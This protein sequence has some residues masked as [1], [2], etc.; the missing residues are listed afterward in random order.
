[1]GSIMDFLRRLF[2]KKKEPL[3][4]E[5][6]EGIDPARHMS[7]ESMSGML[8]PGYVLQDRYRILGILGIGDLAAV[9]QA[10]DL[11]F[12]DV[13]KLVAVKE[14]INMATDQALREQIARNCKREG[15]ILATL[16]HPAV[17]RIY[18]YFSLG[19]RAYLIMEYIQGKD[20]ES[21][22]NS[23]DEF[24][25]VE[26]VRE[27][28]IELCDV[29]HYLHTHQPPIVFRNM[30]PSNVMIDA[31]R[32]VRL[33][34]FAIA[35]AYQPGVKGT[36]IGA[37]G[38][39]PPEQYEGYASPAGDVYGLGATLHHILTRTDPRMEPPFS[40]EDR[41]IRDYNPDVP[42]AFAAIVVRALAYNPADR[43]ASAE[44]MKQALEAID[45]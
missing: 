34:D 21:I 25:P 27:W 43:F 14:M 7:Q 35:K 33:I 22:L 19:D 37:E 30:K 8:Q 41:P 26:L 31:L 39:S 11:H 24:L 44:E 6:S 23:T 9:Y 20:L 16:S 28:A 17:P 40:F 2:G 38:Y 3:V 15:E 12:P 13:T 32:H 4:G 10:R 5:T 1:M 42:E 36:R 29:L 18:D 45:G